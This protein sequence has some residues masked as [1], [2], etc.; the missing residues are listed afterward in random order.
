M[1]NRE[2]SNRNISDVQKAFDKAIKDEI[3]ICDDVGL[4][5]VMVPF[6]KV[7]SYELNSSLPRHT[8]PAF[9]VNGKEVSR[10]YISK[11]LNIIYDGRAYSLKDQKPCTMVSFDEAVEAC[12]KK[13]RGWGL[14]PASLWAALSLWCMKNKTIPFGNTKFGHSYENP[15]LFGKP[16]DEIEKSGGFYI[17]KTGSGPDVWNHNHKKDGIT[18]LV[19]NIFEWQAGLRSVGAEIQVIPNADSMDSNISLAANSKEWRGINRKGEYT[20]SEEESLYLDFDENKS[21]FIY[22]DKDKLKSIMNTA[23]YCE[24]RNLSIDGIAT[25]KLKELALYPVYEKEKYK[26]DLFYMANNLQEGIAFRGG[27]I[28]GDFMAGLFNTGM[29]MLRNDKTPYIGFRCVYYDL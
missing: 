16:I 28:D 12:R 2:M 19:G 20:S 7:Q 26:R 1:I 6:D 11:Y 29:N 27:Y 21:T 8:H 9:I 4:P 13:G 25:A 3:C 17:T 24:F 5:S 14:M 15:Q 23:R 22:K 18:D 10:V